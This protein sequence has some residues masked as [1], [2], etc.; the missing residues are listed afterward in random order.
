MKIELILITSTTYFA[1]PERN[2]VLY[3]LPVTV[4]GLFPTPRIRFFA[5]ERHN[6]LNE[7]KCIQPRSFLVQDQVPRQLAR[8]TGERRRGTAAG[9]K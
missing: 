9:Y 2:A 4:Q 8:Y 3:Y 5:P 7:Q 1:L 6:L